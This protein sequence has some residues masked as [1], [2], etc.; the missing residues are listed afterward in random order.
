ME[1]GFEIIIFYKYTRV[2]DPA[3]FVAWM[4]AMCEDVGV[5]GRMLI[6]H[7]GINGTVEGTPEQIA[8]YERRLHAQDGSE[9][10]FGDFSDVWFKSSPGTGKAFPKLKVKVRKEIVTTGLPKEVDVDPN[11]VTGK[12]IEPEEL[13]SWIE[14]GVEFEIIDMRNDYE[15]AVGHFAGSHDSHMENFRDLAAVAPKFEHLKDKK[16]LT[17][18]TYGVRCEKASGYLKQQGFQ[19]VYQ[20]HGGI[21]T[22]MKKYPGQDFVGSLYVFDDRMTEQFTDA[23][24]VV[25]ACVR[26]GTKSER[27]GNCAWGECHK[28]LIICDACAPDA[29][30]IWCSEACKGE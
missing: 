1:T 9:G 13:K 2:A 3:G 17:V 21:G 29:K 6:A 7:E 18:C 11:Q 26:C 24:E 22:Y 14:N 19:D 12:H 8:E 5:K 16:V 30:L 4:R 20:L 23:Y 10:T 27:Y 25:G 15:Y 28:Q